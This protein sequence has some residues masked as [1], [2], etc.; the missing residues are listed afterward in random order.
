MRALSMQSRKVRLL[1]R[2][3]LDD[4]WDPIRDT[5]ITVCEC[6]QYLIRALN[7]GGEEAAGQL[8]SQLGGGRSEDARALA[9]RLYAIC[10]RKGWTQEALAYNS[11]VASWGDVQAKTM[12]ER[13]LTQGKMDLG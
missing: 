12:V 10:E 7:K 5:R 6:A 3:E 9:Y 1:K 13:T 2:D 11:L 4:D 8:A